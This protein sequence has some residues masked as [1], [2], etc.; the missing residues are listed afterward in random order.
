MFCSFQIAGRG[1]RLLSCPAQAQM[2]A[3]KVCGP[4]AP[5]KIQTIGA[6]AQPSRMINFNPA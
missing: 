6:A 4:A 5:G 1:D 2:M 3:F